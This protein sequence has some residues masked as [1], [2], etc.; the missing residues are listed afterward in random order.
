MDKL[1]A[2]MVI[3]I[4]GRPPEHVKESLQTISLRLGS[5]KGVKVLN[6]TIHE[7][8]PAHNSKSLFT[9]FVEI[10]LEIDN[11]ETYLALLFGY[12]PSNFEIIRPENISFSNAQITDIG[13]A[14]IQKVH[15]YDA[16]TKKYIYERDFILNEVKKQSPEIY[17]KLI[18]ISKEKNK[19]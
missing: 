7:P 15:S 9:S 10:E 11:V 1:H 4:L 12:L 17:K 16:V 3:E 2:N 6:K 19:S 18:E 5:E 8:I 14:I 13:N